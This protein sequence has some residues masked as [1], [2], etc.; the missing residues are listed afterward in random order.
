MKRGSSRKRLAGS[1]NHSA[2][3][4]MAYP[5]SDDHDSVTSFEDEQVDD[6]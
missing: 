3:G 2:R 5:D 4:G 1:S 6:L